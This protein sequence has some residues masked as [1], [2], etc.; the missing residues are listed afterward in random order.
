MSLYYEEPKRTAAQR[1]AWKNTPHLDAPLT[2]QD[3][4]RRER[5]EKKWRAMLEREKAKKR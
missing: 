1:R 3:I 2:T 4:E 5:I